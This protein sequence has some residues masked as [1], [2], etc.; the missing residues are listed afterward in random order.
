[1]PAPDIVS[2]TVVN[3]PHLMQHCRTTMTLAPRDADDA[4]RRHSASSRQRH[5]PDVGTGDGRE[6][7]FKELNEAVLRPVRRRCTNITTPGYAGVDA[8]G[9]RRAPRASAAASSPATPRG[10][11]ADRDDAGA[12]PG[13]DLRL[14]PDHRVLRGRVR[15]QEADQLPDAGHLPAMQGRAGSRASSRR[16]VRLRG[17]RGGRVAQTILGQM[18]N[19]VSCARCRGEGRIIA[20]MHQG[21]EPMEL[22]VSAR[23]RSQSRRGL[24]TASASRLW[25]RARPVRRG[26]SN[27]GS[28]VAVRVRGAS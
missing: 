17:G 18:V 16:P 4:D 7:R 5:H 11:P 14:R 8:D 27:G 6:E 24:T 9:R 22:L 13:A 10:A 12:T 28:Y 3:P 2:A 15:G 25:A 26:G 21:G 20:A 1:M 19:I 23:S